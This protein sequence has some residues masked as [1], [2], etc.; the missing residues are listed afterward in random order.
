MK[1]DVPYLDGSSD[2]PLPVRFETVLQVTDDDFEI[3]PK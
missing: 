2:I 3:I 1:T